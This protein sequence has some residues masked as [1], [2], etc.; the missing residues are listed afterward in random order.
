MSPAQRVEKVFSPRC[1]DFETFKKVSKSCLI[2]RAVGFLPPAHTPRCSVSSVF[3]GVFQQSE[4]PACPNIGQA[5]RRR[6]G[7]FHHAHALQ[8]AFSSPH[9]K[10]LRHACS[11]S[12]GSRRA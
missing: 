8:K 6:Y 5:G 12:K 2:E 7:R 3:C 11:P 4:R 1:A 9:G 10:W